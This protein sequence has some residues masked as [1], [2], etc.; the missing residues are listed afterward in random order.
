MSITKRIDA[1][2]HIPKSH[3]GV[4]IPA[5][6]S[7]KVELTAACDFKCY[8]CATSQNLRKK[9]HMD[10]SLFKRIAVEM[11]AAGVEELGL[12]YLGESF[13]Y[14]HLAEAVRFAKEE[15]GFPY[16]FLTANGNA[17]T[18]EKIEAVMRAGLDSLKWS[19]NSADAEQCQEITGVDAFAKVVETIKAAD[20]IRDKVLDETGHRCRLYASSIKYD[21][22]QQARME[23]AVGEIVPFVDEHYWLPL[24]NQA[25]L[26]TKAEEAKGMKPTAGN[27]GRVGGLVDP[28]PCWAL[29]TEGHVSWD[30]VLTGCC[31]SHTP[32]F[33]FGDLKDMPFMEAWN[34]GHAQLLRVA[35]LE[36]DVKGTPCESCAAYS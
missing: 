7:V 26:A 19:F 32:D 10:L 18:P 36:R 5:P 2:T 11:R 33:D 4:V 23:S 13:L 25:G 16:V 6:R 17:A 3:T 15:A 24:Y 30:G 35:H 14:K 12:F 29:F 9:G 31:F 21:G 20:A 34:S 27:M 28:L 8:F 1:I 22:A